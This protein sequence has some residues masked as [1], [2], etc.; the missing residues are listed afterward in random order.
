MRIGDLGRKLTTDKVATIF[1]V[2]TS[3][4]ERY[5]ERYGGV[6]VGRKCL[7]FENLVTELVRKCYALQVDP[8][9]ESLLA[10]TSESILNQAGEAGFR[11]DPLGMWEGCRRESTTELLRR[12]LCAPS[13]RADCR[14]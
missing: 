6:K 8:S 7:F 14:A 5:P 1:E 12:A 3:T 4:V 2:E 13:S 9:R 10:G 11:T